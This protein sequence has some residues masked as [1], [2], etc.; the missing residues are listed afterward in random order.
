MSHIARL[1][2]SFAAVVAVL[3]LL[4]ADSDAPA[5]EMV[6][7]DRTYRLTST[8]PE[9]GEETFRVRL[10]SGD[11]G[12]PWPAE[13]SHV[14]GETTVFD[15]SL[16][17]RCSED[18]DPVTYTLLYISLQP[19]APGGNGTLECFASL[20]GGPVTCPSRDPAAGDCTTT[21]DPTEGD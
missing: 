5:C 9:L 20:E 15:A 11:D 7:F 17:G 14:D 19:S 13:L 21:I 18:G 10:A 3:A 12:D 4:L 16:E 6:P 8:C 1:A 2:G